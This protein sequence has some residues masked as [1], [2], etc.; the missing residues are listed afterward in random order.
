MDREAYWSIGEVAE[1]CDL[2]EHTL[3]WYERI[4]LVDPVERGADGRRRYRQ[5]DLDRIMLLTRLR[6]TGMPV[7]TMQR[8]TELVR[9]GA[10]V[11]ERLAIIEAHRELVR[12]ALATQQECLQLLDGKVRTYSQQLRATAKE[13]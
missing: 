12:S 10:G 8:Y 2:T 9:D 5:R 11:A 1:K 4:G 7:A 6:A 3:R 13:N